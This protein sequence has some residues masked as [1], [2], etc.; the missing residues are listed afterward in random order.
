MTLAEQTGFGI[1]IKY[2]DCNGKIKK[3]F[4]EDHISFNN[5]PN[6]FNP[7]SYSV[8]FKNLVCSLDCDGK[9]NTKFESKLRYCLI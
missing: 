6:R 3:E 2:I 1:C 7:H 9:L 4:Y 5:L 8:K